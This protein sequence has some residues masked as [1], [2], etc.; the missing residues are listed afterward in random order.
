MTTLR[1]CVSRVIGTYWRSETKT[2]AELLMDCE[3][4][5]Q[6]RGVVIGILREEQLHRDTE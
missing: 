4:S 3:G 1:R 6:T 5:V 2:F